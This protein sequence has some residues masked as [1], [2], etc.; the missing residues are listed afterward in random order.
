MTHEQQRAIDTL[1]RQGYAI[2][3][4]TPEEVG[5]TD[6]DGLEAIMVEHGHSFIEHCAEEAA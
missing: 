4:F 2:A 6:C 1:R 3:L 5:A